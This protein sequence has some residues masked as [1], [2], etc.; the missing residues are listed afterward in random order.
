M[1]LS[2]I[3]VLYGHL[4]VLYFVPLNSLSISEPVPNYF[5]VYNFTTCFFLFKNGYLLEVYL[6][7]RP[8]I[9]SVGTSEFF[10][11]EYNHEIT[12]QI[13]KQNMT[14]SPVGH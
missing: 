8:Q 7:K 10:Q 4:Y 14:S 6:G 11:S 1:I 13:K 2:I 12:T 5:N 3:H 9:I